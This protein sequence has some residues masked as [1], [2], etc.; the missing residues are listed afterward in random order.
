MVGFGRDDYGPGV[1]ADL[2][3]A[4]DMDRLRSE[5]TVRSEPVKLD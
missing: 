2:G 4:A 3:R 1:L 5:G